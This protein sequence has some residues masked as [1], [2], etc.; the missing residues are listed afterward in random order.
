MRAIILGQGRI[1]AACLQRAW[2]SPHASAI[3]GLIVDD[4]IADL[5]RTLA[6]RVAA[7]ALLSSAARADDAILDLIRRTGAECLI[8]VQY[9]WILP[10]PVLDAVGG[11][12]LNLHNARLPDYR[13]HNALTHIILADDAEHTVTLHW[14]SPVVDRGEHCLEATVRIAPDET[15]LSLWTKSLDAA[16]GLFDT[17]LERYEQLRGATPRPILGEGHF[18]SKTSLLDLK[19]IPDGADLATIDRYA[20]AFHFPPHEPAYFEH[21]DG[22]RTYV[23]PSY[24]DPRSAP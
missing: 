10:K 6:P 9:P 4:A 24:R 20:R 11:R 19:C 23:V 21:V 5:A 2:T 18:Y 14:M 17:A 16:V 22:R 13:G 12:A 3:V 1:A 15:A 8:S 7:D